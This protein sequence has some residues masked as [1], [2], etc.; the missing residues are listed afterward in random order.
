MSTIHSNTQHEAT[1]N[2]HE[3]TIKMYSEPYRFEAV[4][5]LPQ[6]SI[7]EKLKIYKSNEFK[8]MNGERMDLKSIFRNYKYS[9]VFTNFKLL[10]EIFLAFYLTTT[11]YHTLNIKQLLF[12]IANV[13]Y[14]NFVSNSLNMS[15]NINGIHLNFVA[16]FLTYWKQGNV[17]FDLK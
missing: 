4:I 2:K 17:K 9:F 12:H 14:N 5:K 16:L 13:Y 10:I 15:I 11:T 3:F 7:G 1:P 6:Q 8:D